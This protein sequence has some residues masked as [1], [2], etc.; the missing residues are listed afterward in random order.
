MI[1]LRPLAH[2]LATLLLACGAA[3]PAWAAEP[4]GDHG[5]GHVHPATSLLFFASAEAHRF[6][7]GTPTRD[8]NEDVPLAADIVLT[9]SRDRFRVFGE[10]LLSREEHDLERFQLGYEA[11]PDTMVWFGRFHQP[12]S[13]WNLEHHHGRYVQTAVTRPA[14][15]LWEDEHG[16][17]PQHLTGLLIESGRALDDEAGLRYSLG[18]GLGVS[19][20]SDG[21]EPVDLLDMHHRGHRLSWTG[22]L[23]YVP[24]AVEPTQFGLIAARHTMPVIDARIAAT[25]GA[26]RLTQDMLGAFVDWRHE[27]WRLAAT[28]YSLRTAF[29]GGAS[30]RHERFL[31]GYL[32]LERQLPHGLTAFARDEDSRRARDSIYVSTVSP[33]FEIRR[34]SAG[35]RWDWLRRQALTIEHGN[36]VTSHG[37]QSDVRLLW[38]AVFP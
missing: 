7:P 2:R 20:G 4:E 14:T 19:V 33:N 11:A 25:L 28:V 35:L 30:A 29:D 1:A 31:V 24:Q 10:F 21:L 37:R 17:L 13:A 6:K 18:A 16:I 15:E 12:A 38:S 22:R 23:A 32:Q 26:D 36:G 5:S 9:V 3:V 27:P 34:L 8:V